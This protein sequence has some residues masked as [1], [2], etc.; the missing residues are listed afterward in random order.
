MSNTTNEWIGE[1]KGANIGTQ[2]K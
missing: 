1:G 2:L